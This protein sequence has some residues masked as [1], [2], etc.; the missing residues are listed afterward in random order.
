MRYLNLDLNMCK[1]LNKS[2]SR[3][4]TLMM[5]LWY[6]PIKSY[7]NECFQIPHLLTLRARIVFEHGC[8]NAG[9]FRKQFSPQFHSSKLVHLDGIKLTCLNLVQNLMNL[10]FSSK[11]NRKWPKND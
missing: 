9:N 8:K 4:L 3:Y 10:V 6:P 11:G 1:Y 2:H 7:L 5:L